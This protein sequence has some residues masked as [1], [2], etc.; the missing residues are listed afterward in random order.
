MNFGNYDMKYAISAYT[1][2]T[3]KGEYLL[4]VLCLLRD[5]P[6]R[7]RSRETLGKNDSGL[8]VRKMFQMKEAKLKSLFSN[9]V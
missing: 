3:C 7:R 1:F 5:N 9:L 6:L 4:T 2:L 8:F